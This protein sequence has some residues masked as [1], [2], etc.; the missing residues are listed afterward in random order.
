MK[1]TGSVRQPQSRSIAKRAQILEASSQLFL[2]LGYDAVSLDMVVAKVSGTKSNIYTHFGDKAGLFAAVVEEQWRDSIRPFEE[3]EALDPQSMPLDEALR[4]LGRNFLRAILT[5]REIQLHRLV[6]AE[7]AR[8]PH[9]SRLWYS[10]G[11]EH[12]YTLFSTYIE[13]HQRTAGLTSAISARRL[14]SFFLDMLSSEMHMR[15]LIAGAP[16]P[17]K[18]EID[19]LVD[20]AVGIFLHGAGVVAPKSGTSRASRAAAVSSARRAPSRPRAPGGSKSR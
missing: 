11:P 6:V 3:I 5:E 16:S 4:H 7:A 12:A 19:R 18:A 2:E 8:H 10:Y 17:K 15:M 1:K 14:A 9:S 13:K 20:E